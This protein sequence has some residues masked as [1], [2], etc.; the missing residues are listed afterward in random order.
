[1]NFFAGGRAASASFPMTTNPKLQKY[2][3][4]IYRLKKI[5]DL[6]KRSLR[7]IKTLNAKEI[8]KKNQLEKILRQSVDDVKNEISKKKAENKT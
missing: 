3:N 4:V 2:E 7:Q 1:M 8:E 6:E 5:L